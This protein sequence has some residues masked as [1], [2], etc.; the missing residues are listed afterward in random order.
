MLLPKICGDRCL[1]MVPVLALDTSMFMFIR[2]Q[3]YLRMIPNASEDNALE[4]TSG[5]FADMELP[6][7]EEFGVSSDVFRLPKTIALGPAVKNSPEKV[8]SCSIGYR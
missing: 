3:L 6:E 4:Q 7:A 1:P 5:S 8:F 2:Y